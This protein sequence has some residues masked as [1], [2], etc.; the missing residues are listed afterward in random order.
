MA[1]VT[2]DAAAGCAGRWTLRWRRSAGAEGPRSTMA[3]ARR[4]ASA[5]RRGMS[6]ASGRLRQYFTGIS[7]RMAAGFSRAGLK[8]LA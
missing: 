3:A 7:A 5:I 6:R 8:M 1:S 4:G 2:S